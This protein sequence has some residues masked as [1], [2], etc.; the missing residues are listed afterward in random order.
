[1]EVVLMKRINLVGIFALT[2]TLLALGCA[3]AP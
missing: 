3:R 2:T 1:M